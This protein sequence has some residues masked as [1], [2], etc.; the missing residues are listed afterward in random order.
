M[1]VAVGSRRGLE[2]ADLLISYDVNDS[3]KYDVNDS[4]KMSYCELGV[5]DC[6]Q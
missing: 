5:A 4:M 2:E 3:M 1:P 6:C